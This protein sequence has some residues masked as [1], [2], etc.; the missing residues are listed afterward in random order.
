MA[1]QGVPGAQ[2]M[3][4]AGGEP[5]RLSDDVVAAVYPSQHSCVW[6]KAGG[7]TEADTVCVGDLGVTYQQRLAR[8]EDLRALMGSLPPDAVAHLRASN[9]HARED[10]G[11][12]VFLVDTPE[13]SSLYQDTSGYWTG[14][15]SDLRPDLA[16]LAAAGRGNVDGEPVQVPRSSVVDLDYDYVDGHRVFA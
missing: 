13:G 3:A 2:L 9:R 15:L 1:E 8:F 14:I 12:L 5:V 16:I 4:V 7:M 11:A 6:T 10:G